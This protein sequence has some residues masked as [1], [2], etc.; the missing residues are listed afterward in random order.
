[1]RN[2]WVT[3]SRWLSLSTTPHSSSPQF[4]KRKKVGIEIFAALKNINWT[5]PAILL[6]LQHFFVCVYEVVQVGT[7][8]SGVGWEGMVPE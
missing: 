8:E 6:I 4:Y 2:R 5:A 3:V 7:D 1:M